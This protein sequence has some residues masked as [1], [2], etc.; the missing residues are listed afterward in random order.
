MARPTEEIK[1]KLDLVEFIK[2]YLDLKPSGKN[3]KATCPFH[4]EKTPSFMV[5]PD[6]QIWHCFGCGEGGDIFKFLMRYENL[7]FHEVLRVLAE[8]AGI[9][10]RKISIEEQRQFGVLYDLNSASSDFFADM[11]QN[12]SRV[13]SYLKKRGLKEETI[14]DFA[15][16][17]APNGTD[18]LTVYLIN[19]GFAIEDIVRAGLT[20]KTER[21]Q[22]FDRFRGRVMFPI[23]NHFGKVVGFSGRILPELESDNVGK[24]I[25][26]PDTPIFNKSRIL[27]GFFESKRFIQ[28]ANSALLVEGQMDF[29]MV[30]QDGVR[31]VAATSGTALT[32]DHLRTLRRLTNKLII[33][34]DKDSA[35]QLATDRAIDLANSQDFT[36]Y[37]IP[38]DEFKDPA[39]AVQKKPGF[40][41]DAIERSETAMDYFFSKYLGG[42]TSKIENKKIAIRTLLM[43]IKTLW[44]PVERSHWI[45]ELSHK[46]GISEKDLSEELEKLTEGERK[47]AEDELRNI[48]RDKLTRQEMIAEQIISLLAIRSEFKDKADPYI[49]YLPSHYKEA[50]GVILEKREVRPEI[51][52]IIDILSLQS[53]FLFDSFPEDKFEKEID[54]LIME[55]SLEYFRKLR[56]SLGEEIKRAENSGNED[57]VSKKLKEFDDVSRKMQDIKHGK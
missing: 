18:E 51:K 57:I 30:W 26:S 36:T 32:Q 33:G 11:L 42:D 8:R 35:G 20:I 10:L 4:K 19:R 29:L 28:E 13:S 38:L 5:S 16:G 7:E 3:F 17:F 54:K 49:E 22:Y 53:G 25:N 27:Y 14:K 21:G 12:S 48:E 50:Y 55:L 15:I 45:S 39:E 41:K 47:D 9:E 6:R 1:E 44:S 56:D 43:K 37:I 46:T 24:Y 2:G 31:N 23:H 52:N 34:F 40:I